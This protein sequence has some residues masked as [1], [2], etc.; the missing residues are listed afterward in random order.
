[1]WEQQNSV[2]KEQNLGLNQVLVPAGK[3][4]GPPATQKRQWEHQ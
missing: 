2:L 4:G 1:M 3:E